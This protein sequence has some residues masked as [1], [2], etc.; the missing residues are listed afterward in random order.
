MDHFQLNVE[1]NH[2]TLAT[3]T[4]STNCSVASDAGM[5]G[6]LDINRGDLTAGLG[7]RPVPHRHLRR[8][9]GHVHPPRRAACSTAA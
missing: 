4:S 8:R 1:A 3:H 2:A 9:L 5:L 6:S 7:H